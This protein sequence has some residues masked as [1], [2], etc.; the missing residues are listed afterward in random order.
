MAKVLVTGSK[1]T[2]GHLL[3]GAL[4]EAGHEVWETDLNHAGGDMYIRADIAS[5]RQIERVFEQQF[6]YVY[7]LAAEFGRKNGEDYYEDL[8]IT[9]VI[10]TRNL[11]E[12]QKKKGFKMIFMSSSEIYGD[13]E[14]DYLHED[15]P[16][17]RPILPLNDYAMSKWVNEV[18]IMNFEQR[19]GNPVMRLRLFNAYGPGEYYSPYRSVVCLFIYRALHRLPYTVFEGYHRVFMYVDDLLPTLTTAVSR[20]R[21]GQ[22]YNIGGIEYRSVHELSDIVLK[23]TGADPALVEYLPLDAHNTVNKRPDVSRAARDLG[24]SPRVSLEE[25]VPLTVAWMKRV[26]G[27]E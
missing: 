21:P 5:Y 26:Y 10:G 16:L 19:Y 27:R 23:H 24:H 18:Q 15:L 4:R 3:V 22:V 12:I 17:E 14:A 25:G 1:G 9:N 6:D 11:L 2:I 13:T 20:F 8:W 7:H